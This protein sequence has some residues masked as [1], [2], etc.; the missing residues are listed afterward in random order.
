MNHILLKIYIHPLTPKYS[1]CTFTA[2]YLD[3]I[4]NGISTPDGMFGDFTSLTCPFA[5]GVYQTTYSESTS[6]LNQCAGNEKS[7]IIVKNGCLQVN[8]CADSDDNTYGKSLPISV[9]LRLRLH[10][11][12]CSGYA[13]ELICIITFM[14]TI[15]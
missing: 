11:F 5:D 2:V 13:N 8:L 6:V 1:K 15:Q 12:P 9:E 14:C 7:F 10:V 4:D 3:Y